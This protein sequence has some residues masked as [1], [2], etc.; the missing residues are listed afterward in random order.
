MQKMSIDS[1]MK[2]RNFREDVGIGTHYSSQNPD[3]MTNSQTNI[4]PL[5]TRNFS[6]GS[7]IHRR[8]RQR[9]KRSGFALIIT[10]SMMLLLTLLVTGLLSLSTIALRGSSIGG[11]RA[12]A[13]TNARLA[14]MIALGELQQKLGQ[15]QRISAVAD[16]AGDD[17][18]FPIEN[19]QEPGNNSSINKVDKGLSKVLSGTRYWT[20]V[21]ENTNKPEEIF[22]ITPSPTLL[23]WLVSGSELADATSAPTPADT[24]ASVDGEGGVSDPKKAVVLVGANTVGPAS[25]NLDHFVAVPLINILRKTGDAP[26]GS[27]AWWIGDEGVKARLN[28]PA[29][30]GADQLATY[31]ILNSPHRGWETVEELQNYPLP[32]SELGDRLDR[33][34]TNKQA[35]L[36][37]PSLLGED[38]P[39]QHLFHAAT[40]TSV[41]VLADSLNGGLRVDLSTLLAQDLPATAS[42]TFPNAPA[43]NVNI[44]PRI[45]ASR[46][47]GPKWNQLKD[48]RDLAGNG[49]IEELIVKDGDSST[50]S[51]TISPTI[52]DL[53]ILMG[54]KLV[55]DGSTGFKMHPCGKI[56]IALAN[57]YPYPLKWNS[58]L[59]VEILSESPQGNLPSRIWD[60]AGQPAYLPRDRGEAAVFANV[61]FT[62]PS[63]TL[64]PGEARAYTMHSRV[65]RPARDRRS[66]T[67]ELTPFG[68][69]NPSDFNNSI[70]LAHDSVNT[71]ARR[72]DVRESWTTSLISIELRIAGY[73]RRYLRRIEH[74]ELDNGF[75]SQVRRDVSA[76]IARRYRSPFPLHLFSFQMSQPG[77]DYASVLPGRNLMG[78][79]SSTVRTYTDFN[80]QGKL[81]HAAIASYNPPPYFMDTSDSLAEL[82]FRA[83][84]GDTGRGFTRNLISDPLPWGHSP[85]AAEQTIIFSPPKTLVSIAQLQHADLTADD[86]VISVGHQPGNAV[87]NSYAN[88]FVTRERT[89]QRRKD[90]VITG[91]P[92]RQEAKSRSHTYYDISYLLNASL[93]D[94]YFFSSIPNSSDIVPLS[95][96]MIVIPTNN[97]NELNDPDKVAS[98]L[99]LDGA[100]NI[101]STNPD[102]WKALL[103][104]SQHL[105]HPSNGGAAEGGAYFPR[106]LEQPAASKPSPSGTED[107]SWSGYRRIP[108]DQL[109]QLAEEITKQVRL[110]GPFVSLSHFVNRTIVKLKTDKAMGRSGTLQSA[111]DESGLN[112][113]SSG[114]KNIFSDIRVRDDRVI[115]QANGKLPRA[116]LDGGDRTVFPKERGEEYPVWPPSSRDDNPGS[117]ASILADRPMLTERRYREEQ[118]Y[119]SSG[120]PGWLTQADVLQVIGPSLSARSDTFRIRAYGQALDPK[121]GHVLAKAWCEAIVQRSPQY[122]DPADPPSTQTSELNPT[123][124]TYGRR[125]SIVSFRWLSANEI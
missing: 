67:V 10:I 84:G 99:L 2:N 13:R 3:T 118:G 30:Y 111:I 110:R 58:E 24:I 83:P 39:L 40:T 116:D 56:A 50:G 115:L 107:D 79:R 73:K 70:Q 100:F 44:I 106:S 34:V 72:L 14:L 112:I 108:E 89:K 104:S 93:W 49:T 21:W 117:M 46:I 87:G 61:T 18:G 47:R 69:G 54:V 26:S 125:F 98:H 86:H 96:S 91:S 65:L 94:H 29:P 20:G 80:V 88:P 53:R 12:M 16:I 22:K 15:D 38:S 60:A 51:Q 8:F 76:T 81:F 101:N 123:N 23:G 28:S 103:A 113:D 5:S 66:L 97:S 31:E 114:R 64:A 62:I 75:F 37:D 122:V 42:S 35:A 59:E 19:D 92:N 17:A 27:Y 109:D 48:F 43:D 63:D 4:G 7:G 9:L 121:T 105:A 120:I 77:A 55:H 124:T 25:N 85:F 52:T 45:A 32:G 74:M 119:R 90:Y 41:G 102:A 6:L 71:N 82:P 68:D 36:L 11:P 78:T 95:R 33:V 57:P 1:R